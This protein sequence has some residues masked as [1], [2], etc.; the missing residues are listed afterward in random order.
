MTVG[1]T[2]AVSGAPIDVHGPTIGLGDYRVRV[3]GDGGAR[4]ALGE[5]SAASD[6]A[7]GPAARNM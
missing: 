3:S 1:D 5:N 2:A 4:G 6:G 7:D